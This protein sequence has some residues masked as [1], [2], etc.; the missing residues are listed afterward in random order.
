M[1]GLTVLHHL[2]ELAQNHVIESVMSS[3]HLILCHSILLLPA[4]LPSIKVFFNG[5]ALRMRWLK[6]WNFSFSISSSNEYSGLISFRL[7]GLIF[8]QSKQL[9]RVFFKTMVQKHQFFGAQLSLWSNSHIKAWLWEN[10]SSSRWT[11]VGKV[12][13]LL[14]IMQ[15][16]LVIA[17]LPR[18]NHL[19]FM[20]AVTICSDFGVQ[21]NKVCC[22][23]HFSPSISNEMVGPYAMIIFSWMLSFR[24]AFSLSSF[25]LHQEVL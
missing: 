19:N 22:F 12:M 13:S 9:S 18:N 6:Y 4:V 15:S 25:H 16:R 10:R 20:T 23:F 11:F 24:P 2:P 21:E 17:F 8:L 14:F 5:L 7:T 3:N 1:P